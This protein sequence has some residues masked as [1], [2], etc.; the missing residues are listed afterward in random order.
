MGQGEEVLIS[1]KEKAEELGITTRTLDRWVESGK[2]DFYYLPDKSR[3]QSKSGRHR[4][5]FFRQGVQ[6]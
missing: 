6:L 1:K 4:R 3:K 2:I 5:W